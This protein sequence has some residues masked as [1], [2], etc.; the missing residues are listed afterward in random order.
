[1]RTRA[2]VLTHFMAASMA[3]AAAGGAAQEARAA[4]PEAK[5]VAIFAEDDYQEVEL[6]YP[7]Y[8]LREAGFVVSIL[9]TGQKSA[10]LSKTK[11]EVK[12]DRSAEGTRAL[13]FDAV[14]VPGGY[15][16]DR[17]RRY[18]S[19]T[20]LVRETHRQG[21]VVAA[22]CHGPSVLLSAGVVKGKRLTSS[23]AIAD[24]LKYAG[25][26]Y[27]DKEN[28]VEDGN[29]ITSRGASDLPVWTRMLVEKISGQPL[30]IRPLAGKRVAILVED[31]YQLIEM[32]YPYYRL[33]EEG[34]AVTIVGTGAK[35]VYTDKGG[36]PAKVDRQIQQVSAAD[37][38]AVIVPGGFAPDLLR[39]YKEVK[40][41]VRAMH[42]GGKVVAAICHGPSLLVS[43]G[44]LQ[45]K[46]VTCV[47]AIKDDVIAAGGD[48][49]DV[50]VAED[51]KLITSRKP[52]DM[53]L[54]LPAII[55][56][57]R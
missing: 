49:R 22:I 35:D 39:R 46:K 34:A 56:A 13:D 25:A 6:L 15:A 3:I 37:F 41:F 57:M 38:D 20:D 40:D 19:V 55:R 47:S 8:R 30:P 36:Y 48:Y 26:V 2:L 11:Y 10:Y 32:W 53:P 43:A 4:A 42:E 51:G 17:L 21:K 31:T 18:A 27:Q 16:P 45:G 44:I 29:L 7:L 12:V 24:D 52:D 23:L 28:V 33:L 9:G 54:W 1:M 50:A 14:I 5:R